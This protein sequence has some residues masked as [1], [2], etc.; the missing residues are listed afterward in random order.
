MDFNRSLVSSL[1]ELSS[2]R[3]ELSISTRSLLILLYEQPLALVHPLRTRSD[4][5]SHFEAGMEWPTDVCRR[6]PFNEI[7][8][9]IGASP[10]RS[11]F[12]DI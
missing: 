6:T 11:I 8:T 9:W 7:V 3:T 2:L 1:S 4:S 10:F 5:A 12:L